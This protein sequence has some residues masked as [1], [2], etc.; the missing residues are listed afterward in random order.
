MHHTST[1]DNDPIAA[2][3]NAMFYLPGEKTIT[4]VRP[5]GY[6]LDCIPDRPAIATEDAEDVIDEPSFKSMFWIADGLG[7]YIF[8]PDELIQLKRLATTYDL[9][10]ELDYA[11]AVIAAESRVAEFLS[12]A[13]DA[14]DDED[15]ADAIRDIAAAMVELREEEDHVVAERE[16][17]YAEAEGG[18]GAGDQN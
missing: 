6:G 4:G 17:L 9:A 8:Q 2:F 10:L 12:A 5:I 13:I 15:K 7:R 16:R 18:D 14:T 1:G 11:D 3:L